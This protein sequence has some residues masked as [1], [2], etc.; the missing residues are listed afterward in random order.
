MKVGKPKDGRVVSGRVL[1]SFISSM[2]MT[3]SGLGTGERKII[4]MQSPSTFE[5]ATD[6][7]SMKIHIQMKL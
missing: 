1:K 7:E 3:S 6:S 2:L 4:H 5:T